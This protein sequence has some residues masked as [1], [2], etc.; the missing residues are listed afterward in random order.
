MARSLSFLLL[1]AL[2]PLHAASVS[3]QQAD[4]F[5]RKI[6]LIQRQADQVERAGLRRTAL[7]EDELNSWFAYQARPLLPAGVTDPKVTIIGGGRVA[8]QATVDLDAIAKR[9]SSGGTLD[10][11]SYIGG[12]VP[13]NVVG[14]LR[15]RDGTGQFDLQSADISGLPVPKTLL[16]EVV[17]YYSRTPENPRGVRIDDQFA[18]P[19][20]IKQIEVAQGQA[21]IVQ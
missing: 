4:L 14:T 2:V 15:T 3:K 16:Q 12:R 7:T 17:T 10:P 11:W 5:S 8:G 13:V 6:V 19:A 18:L 1:V 21:I 9:R 20:R